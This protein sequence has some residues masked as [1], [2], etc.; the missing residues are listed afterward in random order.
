M[1]DHPTSA[2]LPSAQQQQP[3][4]PMDRQQQQ[5]S[6]AG[7]FQPRRA[8]QAGAH[9]E[10]SKDKQMGEGSYEGTRDYQDSVDNYLKKGQ[11]Q[12]D[13]NAAKP[14]TPDEEEALKKAEKEG[15]SHSKAPGQ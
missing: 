11:V 13:A 15:L 6:G 8:M 7:E 12:S 10:G 4:R 3:K 2:R 5:S 1:K 9:K 14:R